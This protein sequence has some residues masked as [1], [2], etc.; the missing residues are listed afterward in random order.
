[1]FNRCKKPLTSGHLPTNVKNIR[2]TRL[3]RACVSTDVKTA[4]AQTLTS[5]LC[6]HRC[7]RLYILFSLF[8][9][10]TLFPLYN[11]LSRIRRPCSRIRLTVQLPPRRRFT[12]F[13]SPRR[14]FTPFTSPRRW[15]TRF[16]TPRS[17][18]TPFTT[19]RRPFRAEEILSTGKFIT[20]TT[21]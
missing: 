18:F 4:K 20:L 10:C 17:R 5:V 7:K 3:H 15:F 8:P 6:F 16:T 13:T 11:F 1:M 21:L 14:R 12:P 2:K 19:P 9:K